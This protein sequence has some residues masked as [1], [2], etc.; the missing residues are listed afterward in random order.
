MVTDWNRWRHDYAIGP[1]SLALDGVPIAELEEIHRTCHQWMRDAQNRVTM[2]LD[3][4]GRTEQ[5][6]VE[7]DLDRCAALRLN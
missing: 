2:Q 4:P 3:E 7:I 6:T 1:R 5:R